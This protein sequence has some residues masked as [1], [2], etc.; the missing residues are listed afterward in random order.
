MLK[1][2]AEHITDELDGAVDYWTKAVEYKGTDE[3]CKFR[4]MAEME[5]EHANAMLKIF[6]NTEIP[7]AMTDADYGQLNKAIL[8]AYTDSMTKIDAMKKMYWKE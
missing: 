2:L 1:Y 7:K 5:I 3:G 6:R 4:M 8:D